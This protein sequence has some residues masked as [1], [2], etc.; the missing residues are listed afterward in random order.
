VL[1]LAIY[2]IRAHDGGDRHVLA[3]RLIYVGAIAPAVVLGGLL[4]GGLTLL[5]PMIAPATEGSLRISVYGEQWWW[6]IRYEPPGR[7]PFELANEIRLPVGQ[8][9]QFLLHSTNVIHSFWIPSLGGK[10][11][12]IPGR[13]NRL[14]LHPTRTG[15]WRGVCAEF[16]GR[17]HAAMAFQTIVVT[18]DEFQRWI[19]EQS[20]PAAPASA[21]NRQQP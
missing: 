16:C 20:Q 6:R 7:Q 9:V 15:S 14:V 19:T 12:M 1:A 5:R 18:P 2:S 13:T 11:D 17:G 8:P 3:H 4:V 21:A 10:M